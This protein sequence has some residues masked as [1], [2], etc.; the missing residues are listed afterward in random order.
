MT[1]TYTGRK[2]WKVGKKSTWSINHSLS[3]IILAYLKE[4]KETMKT[5]QGI[6]IPLLFAANPEL[7]E[8]TYDWNTF[9]EEHHLMADAYLLVLVDKMLYAFDTSN[10]PKYEGS[11]EMTRTSAAD[12]NGLITVTFEKDEVLWEKYRKESDEWNKK[13]KEGKELFGKWYDCLQD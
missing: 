3:P 11:L 13:V 2:G 12:T 6:Q 4:Y 7:D 10:E 1:I 8:E 5:Q 9:T